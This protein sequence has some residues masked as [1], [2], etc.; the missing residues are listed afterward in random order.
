M[1]PRASEAELFVVGARLDDRNVLVL[2]ESGADG[3]GV[4]ADPA[5]GVRAASLCTL[6]LER[7]RVPAANVLGEHDGTTYAECVRLSRLAWCAWSRRGRSF[8]GSSSEIAIRSAPR[9]P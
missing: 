7:V 5:M 1:V 4:E 2:V 3:L 8:F 6:T 9:L